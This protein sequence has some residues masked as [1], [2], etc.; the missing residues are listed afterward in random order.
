MPEKTAYEVYQNTPR[1]QLPHER[2]LLKKEWWT[3]AQAARAWGVSTKTARRYFEQ[4]GEATT[5]LTIDVRTDKRRALR[6][7]R[8]GTLRP[9]VRR[10]NPRFADSDWQRAN[11]CKRWEGGLTAE[12]R[13]AVKAVME[14]VEDAAEEEAYQTLLEQIDQYLPP[15]LDDGGIEDWEPPLYSPDPDPPPPHFLMRWERDAYERKQARLARG[16]TH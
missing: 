8:A 7:V 5:V 2:A 11:S 4:M 1:Y 16:C 12:E 3:A 9:P 10:G 6:C 14:A 15:E 13:E